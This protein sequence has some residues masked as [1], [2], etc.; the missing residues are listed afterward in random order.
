MKHALYLQYLKIIVK[1]AI[2]NSDG[3]AAGASDYLNRMKK[4]GFF[5]KPE[6]REAYYRAQKVFATTRDRPLWFV[7][8]CLG[9]K[10]EDLDDI[11]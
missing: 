10:Q 7:L 9:L 6:K 5:S 1:E 8:S 2:E 4:P 3:T 11:S